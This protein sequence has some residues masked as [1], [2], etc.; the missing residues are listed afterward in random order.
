MRNHVGTGHRGLLVAVGLA[1][2]GLATAIAPAVPALASGQVCA[3]IVID[4]GTGG[5]APVSQGA[6]VPPGSSDLDLLS[7]AGDTFTQNDSGLICAINNYPPNGLENCLDA[8]HGLFYYW[9]YWEGD[10]TTNTWTYANVGPSEHTVTAG[11]SYVEGWRYQDPGPDS[12]DATKPSVKPAK[13]FARACSGG[14]SSPPPSGGGTG[15]GGSGG[16]VTSTTGAPATSPATSTAR[17]G[18]N[19]PAPVADSSAS[20]PSAGT[21]TTS[22]SSGT[23]G[24]RSART[25]AQSQST[26]TV[27]SAPTTEPASKRTP[28]NLALASAAH[29]SS[30]G[31]DPALPI[32]LIA[33]L[34]GLIGAAS[35]FKWRRRPAEE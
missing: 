19:V 11:Q 21:S 28:G 26:T 35:W 5:G 27:Q 25:G 22:A 2:A 16:P 8:A 30:S 34:I 31:G 32:V 23:T 15:G 1:A 3:G 4:D 7:A 13:A 29:T 10:P 14:S 18:S 12:P 20:Q 6:S 24:T 33:L 17:S 9:S